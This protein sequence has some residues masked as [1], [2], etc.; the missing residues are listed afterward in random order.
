MEA[1]GQCNAQV[2]EH[3]YNRILSCSCVQEQQADR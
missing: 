1:W 3:R 2:L